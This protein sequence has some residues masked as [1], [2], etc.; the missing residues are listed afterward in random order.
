MGIGQQI[1]ARL[2][3]ALSPTRLAVVDD[4]EAHR[5]HGGYREGGETHFRVEIASDVLLPLSRIERHRTIHQAIGKDL[6]SQ[7]HALEIVIDA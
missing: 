5:G 6:V 2:E 3:T 7:I 1:E 4:S